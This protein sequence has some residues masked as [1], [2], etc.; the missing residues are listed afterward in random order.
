MH[1]A[2]VTSKGQITIP[3]AMREKL[4]LQSG[5]KLFFEELPNGDF[6]IRRKTGDIRDLRGI[7]K[8]KPG[9]APT[10]EDMKDAI[11][12]AIAEKHLAGDR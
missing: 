9:F 2:T 10:V 8:A 12:L 11:G 3:A 4:R 7:L 1:S 6:L 5:S